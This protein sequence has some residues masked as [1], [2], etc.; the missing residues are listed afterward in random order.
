M[1]PLFRP[2][3]TLACM[4][5]TVGPHA[6]AEVVTAHL[7]SAT[8]APVAAAGYIATGN[9]VDLSLDFAPAT[10]ATLTVVNNTALAFIEGTFDNLPQG[11]EVELAFGGRTYGFVA[12][13][14]GGTGNDLVLQWAG[15]RL[16]AWGNNNGGQLGN[17]TSPIV[18]REPVAVTGTGV[19]K[20]R[21]VIAVSMG[22][23]HS[24]ALCSDGTLASWGS[25][26]F[27]QLGNGRI[28][29]P[30]TLEP[31]AVLMT[32]ALAGKRVVA[33]CAAQTH[34]VVLCSD[35]TV[36]SWGHEYLGPN[37]YGARLVPVALD[38]T[39]VLAGKTV[40]SIVA[41]AFDHLALCS[42]GTLVGW[43]VNYAGILGNQSDI[44]SAVPVAVNMIGALAGKSVT[45]I[46]MGHY[47]ALIQCTDGTVATWGENTFG[48][49]NTE[50]GIPNNIPAA[51][52]MRGAL[53]GKTI[54]TL[55]GGRYHTLALCSDG[56][57]AAWGR[58]D[59]GQLG[60]GSFTTSSV[61]VEVRRDGVLA[62][63][64]IVNISAG[65]YQS[66]A[67][68]SDGTVVT[69]G[70]NQQ[71]SLGNGS[72]SDSNVPVAVSTALL[73]PGERFAAATTTSSAEHAIALV[74]V[75]SPKIKV[76]G[77]GY[78]ILSGH[79]P[80]S[81]T[82][83]IMGEQV[84]YTFSIAN[85]GAPFLRLTGPQTVVL[86]GEDAEDFEVTVQPASAI[87]PGDSTRFAITFDPS[88]LGRRTA[89][90][91]IASNDPGTPLSTFDISGTGVV[92]ARLVPTI[93]FNPPAF[94]YVSQMPYTWRA[95]TSSGQRA[96][97][98]FQFFEPHY[99]GDFHQVGDTLSIGIPGTVKVHAYLDF[100]ERYWGAVTPVHT[101]T[102]RADPTTLTLIDLN[103]VY[104]G[105]P[106]PAA[107][108]GS[109]T[110]STITYKVGTAYGPQAPTNAGTYPVKAV[111]GGKTVTGTLV[112]VKAPLY[113]TPDDRHKFA[114]QANPGRTV[115]YSGFVNGETAA[116]LTKTP[117]LKTTATTN[118]IGGAYPI[119]ASGAAAAN[120]VF[121]YR[122]GYLVVDSHA[123]AYEALLVDGNH[124]PVGKLTVTVAATSKTFTARLITADLVTPAFTGS[125]TTAS[126]GQATGKATTNATAN[127]ITLPWGLDFTLSPLGKMTA[128]VTRLAAPFGSASDGQRLSTK[129][130][131]LAGAHTAVLEP[132]TPA[133]A[134]VPGGAG[135]ATV[136][137]GSTGVLT[138]AGRLGDGT[139]FTTSLN[140][141]RLSDPGY[142]MFLQPYAKP[143]VQ[144]F[145][146]GTFALEHQPDITDLERFFRRYVPQ[147]AMTWKKTGLPADD[148]YRSGFGPVS[149]VLILYPWL[150][151]TAATKTK[152]AIPLTDRVRIL[153]NTFA[154]RHSPTGSA[155]QA[156]LP[157]LLKISPAHAVSVLAPVT[158]PANKTKWKILTLVPN[159][160]TFTGSFEL[161]DGT[162][163]RTVTFSGVLRQGL[164]SGDSLLGDGHYLLPP[165][166]G[167][168]K[169]TGEILFIW[170]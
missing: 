61:P 133:G 100:T 36:V 142:R 146:A 82:V 40:V 79:F 139:A 159:T 77:Q 127:G 70:K 75:A 119:I 60:D 18:S 91:T 111:A 124:L 99:D 110:P 115:S 81:Q 46:S 150:P 118:S 29:S 114:G 89:T 11:Q 16:V 104:D 153:D 125:L 97:F 73:A 27:G 28:Y 120:Y 62:G 147:Q 87:A 6:Y 109:A 2:L 63:K 80:L 90:V 143:R 13:Y 117:A 135:W 47:H 31:A 68:C 98:S 9:S 88:L 17:K 44:G 149:T 64:T 72:Y 66:Q 10:G 23:S 41:G 144:S 170:P 164:L 69:W 78:P 39:G 3:F 38:T 86:S 163:K 166:T 105:L 32:G 138:F 58:N 33:V 140:A 152:P 154:V 145:L 126:N 59:S 1:N 137:A 15:V 160:G 83:N 108:L 84:T 57:L 55:A 129:P 148:S 106:K 169:T 56:T 8:D 37:N 19:L 53:A 74:A 24:L 165:V 4:I 167:T 134:S 67:L 30:P 136:N 93:T 25:N 101:L 158:V 94:L 162:L 7:S 52:L 12:N 51:V 156:D 128:S 155:S 157:T 121:I 151:P 48:M 22:Q 85:T 131:L 161:V 130:V 132:A 112:I 141:D 42:D 45:A 113:V 34:S 123:G 54:T 95:V 35:G 43:G 26:G 92:P 107:T 14:Y 71:G 116:V 50:P 96:Q 102:I 20:G 168:E 103:Q 49:L 122:Q 65:L 21:T 76:T 5:F